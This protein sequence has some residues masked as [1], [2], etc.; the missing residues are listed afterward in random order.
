MANPK[1]ADQRTLEDFFPLE[2][3][4]VRASGGKT[5]IGRQEGDQRAMRAGIPVEGGRTDRKE[6]EP[7]EGYAIYRSRDE[8]GEFPEEVAAV[9]WFGA[10]WVG[11]DRAKIARVSEGYELRLWSWWVRRRRGPRLE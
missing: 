10:R 4:R 2:P 3:G 8:L 7:G 9:I 11:V 5:G 6:R 1:W